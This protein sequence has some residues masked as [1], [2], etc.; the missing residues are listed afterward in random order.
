MRPCVKTIKLETITGERN[1]PYGTS[2]IKTNFPTQSTL[3]GVVGFFSTAVIIRTE[4]YGRVSATV[5]FLQ[6]S[7]ANLIAPKRSRE[8]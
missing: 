6:F 8:C 3:D 4:N 7:V 5:Y 2:T 1:A